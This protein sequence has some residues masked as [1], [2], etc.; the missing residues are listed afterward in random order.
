MTART[1]GRPLKAALLQIS[2]S[3]FPLMAQPASFLRL[4]ALEAASQCPAALPLPPVA[5]DSPRI[6]GF[7]A[8][9]QTWLY[10]TCR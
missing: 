7:P 4:T 1:D 2:S 5:T 3:Y 8:L 10:Q 6:P 9:S